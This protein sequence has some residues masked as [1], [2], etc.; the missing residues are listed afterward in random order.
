MIK[1]VFIFLLMPI[2]C[3]G[4]IRPKSKI[5]VY[6][7]SSCDKEIWCLDCGKNPE[8]RADFIDGS[9]TKYFKATMK[10][11][12]F[13]GIDGFI[14]IQV[15][16]GRDGRV[17]CKNINQYTNMS[18]DKI[19]AYKLDECVAKMPQ[20]RPANESGKPIAASIMIIIV[21]TKGEFIKAEIDRIDYS[22]LQ[23][24]P[25]KD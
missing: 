4:Q 14:S 24:T 10:K 17:C 8:D 19:S 7:N 3:M 11:K 18:N 15:I 13:K 6:S 22:N 16:V 12:Q 1:L 25:I 2:F 21:I 23:I 5:N 20:W 9:L